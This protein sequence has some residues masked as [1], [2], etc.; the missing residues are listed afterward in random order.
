[1]K[2]SIPKCRR[3]DLSGIGIAVILSMIPLRKPSFWLIFLPPIA[4]AST[5]STSLA[6]IYLEVGE[7][8]VI[9]AASMDQF[10]VSGDCVRH[11]RPANSQQ[12]LLKAL[13]PGVAS[14]LIRNQESATTRQIRIEERKQSPHP[15][16]L[17][18]AL[19]ALHTTE[20]ID[21]GPAFILRGRISDM[22]EA[23]AISRLRDLFPQ[24]IID[25]TEIT[26][27]WAESCI[28]KLTKLIEA[29]PGLKLLYEEGE[30]QIQGSVSN[31]STLHSIRKR[32][33]SI[34]PLTHLDIRAIHGAD[35][36]LYFKVFLLEVKKDLMQR[37]GIQW[38]TIQPAALNLNPARLGGQSS[39]DLGIQALHEK[40]MAR[41]LS[42]P[43]LVVKAP[44]QAELFAGGEIPIRQRN[45]FNESVN[46]KSFGLTLRIDVKEFGQDTVRL[47]IETEISHLDSTLNQ[48]EIP[49]LKSNRLKTLVDGK[50]GK[51][52][53][54]S[55]LLQEDLQESRKGLP[56]LSSIPVLGKLFSSEDYQSKRSELVAILLPYRSAPEAPMKRISSQIPRGFLPLP[57]D[58]M[59]EDELDIARRNPDFPWN[60][61]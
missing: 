38:P 19:N 15:H 6:P 9:H 21:S 52:L 33:L 58:R 55:G 51:P 20:V 57:R 53:L 56:G 47:A 14:L 61:L 37:L 50:M 7:Q 23:R 22:E 41:I 39:I 30:F 5:L 2:K 11:W 17:L 59:S 18:R 10:S 28:E 12:I 60:I 49:G 8:R 46:W 24:A 42:S 45:R 34:Q 4:Q 36:T 25:E 29:F 3:G 31:E 26:R 40:G 35:S 16:Q 43:E 48:N 54:L 32:I 27:D 13:C 44:G 1:M